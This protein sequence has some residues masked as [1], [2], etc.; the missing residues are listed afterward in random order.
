[1]DIV[2]KVKGKMIAQK[3]AMTNAMSTK[4]VIAERAN[5]ERAAKTKTPNLI[6]HLLLQQ[7]RQIHLLTKIRCTA[8]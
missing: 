8:T 3:C 4:R 5:T 1:V 6:R 2:K 7:H